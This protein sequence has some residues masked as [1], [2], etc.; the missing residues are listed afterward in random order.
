MAQGRSFAWSEL[1]RRVMAQ[2]QWEKEPKPAANE[3]S[4]LIPSFEVRNEQRNSRR[5]VA[6]ATFHFSQPEVA[7]LL[8]RPNFV[9]ME[10]LGSL[11]MIPL[12]AGNRLTGLSELKGLSSI[13]AGMRVLL[14]ADVRFDSLEDWAKIRAQSALVQE[15]GDMDVIGLSTREADIDLTYFGP[16]EDLPKAMAR[17]HL[18]LSK[19]GGQYTL[20]LDPI[21]TVANNPAEMPAGP[22]RFQAGF[23][24][25]M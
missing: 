6:E 25:E 3:L 4:R 11:Q 12:T 13:N 19:S 18:K 5:Y 10:N 2:D 17:Q 21:A 22:P 14:T 1:F 8:R 7:K 20:E 23:A 9:S 15:I 24:P 16:I